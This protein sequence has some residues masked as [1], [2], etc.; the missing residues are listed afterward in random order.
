L[1]YF[2]EN[3][4]QLPG[5]IRSF[6]GRQLGL[7]TD[8]TNQY[9]WE[10]STRERHLAQIREITGWRSMTPQDKQKLEQWLRQ[11]GALSAPSGEKLLDCACQRLFQLRLELPAEAELQRL[12]NAA[13]NG[14]F[15]DLYE[16]MTAQLPLKVQTQLD[17]LL[18]VPPDGVVSPFESLKADAANPGVNNLQREISKLKTLRTV[19][20]SP[21]AFRSIPWKVLQMLKRRAWNEKASEMREHPHVVRYALLATFVHVR[22]AEVTDNVVKMLVEIIQRLDRRSDQQVYRSWK[23]RNYSL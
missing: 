9:P 8:F 5:S 11:D 14:Y 4:Q 16:Q 7:L 21:E 13:L 10:S 2:P 22:L 20:V 1:G 17:E 12:V 15:Y 3:L 19:G 23:R 18:V 6:I